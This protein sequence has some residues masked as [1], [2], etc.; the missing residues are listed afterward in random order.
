MSWLSDND[1]DVDG[2]GGEGAG[3]GGGEKDL[4]TDLC[5]RVSTSIINEITIKDFQQEP[6]N[7]TR[8]AA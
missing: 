4:D 1:G 6:R 8:T 5:I 7:E 2:D 3:E